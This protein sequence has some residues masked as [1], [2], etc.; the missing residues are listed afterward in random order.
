MITAT[1]VI[2][3]PVSDPHASENGPTPR[4]ASHTV[5]SGPI[6]TAPMSASVRRFCWNSLVSSAFGIEPNPSMSTFSAMRRSSRPPS[7][8]PRADASA[9]AETNTV[10]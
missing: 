2:T 4:A 5:T 9:G 3:F 6:T 1:V 7:L 10:P 8:A